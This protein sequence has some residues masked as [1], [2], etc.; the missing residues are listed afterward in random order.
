M[1]YHC[2]KN[3]LDF[4]Y[5]RTC[6]LCGA[7]SDLPL[8]LC[9]GCRK[10]LPHNRNSCARCGLPLPQVRVAEALCGR[11]QTHAPAFDRC[12]SPYIYRY[13]VTT[14][15]GRLKFN[16]GLLYGRLLA[17][18]LAA[19]AASPEIEVPELL[20]PVPLHPR[21]LR[22]RGFNQAAL[23]ARGVSRRLGI[24]V[25]DGSLRRTKA[26]PPQTGLDQGARLRNLRGAFS[27]VRRPAA[28]HVAILDDVVT[29][30]ATTGEL[31]GLLKAAGVKRVD[32]WSCART[33]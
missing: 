7:A 20:I 19:H 21:R 3:I 5:P 24:P 13:P 30:G 27:L 18:L 28:G 11:C 29:T 12:L 14:M 6:L 8:D 26:T 25:D 23:I 32:V 31:A 22:Q 2:I 10:D 16:N 4:L 15:I 17:D 9:D 33:P 1:V